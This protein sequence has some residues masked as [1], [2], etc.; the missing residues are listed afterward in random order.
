MAQMVRDGTH[1]ARTAQ[2]RVRLFA[3][4]VCMAVAHCA[5]GPA[6]AQTQVLP[7]LVITVP[8][9]AQQQPQAPAAQAP[10]PAQPKPAPKPKPAQQS[11]PKAAPTKS[12]SASEGGGTGSVSGPGVQSISV[13]VNGDPI[14]NYEIEQRA[15]FLS[16]QSNIGERAQENF[17]RLVSQD[18]T[19]QRLRAILQETI[20]AN[21]GKTQQQV[22]AIFEERKK[23]FAMNLQKQ[24]V[25][26]ARASVVPAK[27]KEA[28]DE[29]IEEQL[30]IQEAKRLGSGVDDKQVDDSFKVIASRNKMTP[31]Q[32]SDHMRNMGVDPSTM[33]QKIRSSMAWSEVVRRQIS[34]NVTVSQ[35]EIDRLVGTAGANDTDIEVEVR[36]I[37]LPLPPKLD[38]KTID[39]RL[40]EADTLTSS[41]TS[42]RTMASLSNKVQGAKFEDIGAR[43][44]SS[45]EEPLKSQIAAAKD[46]Q[47]LP[48]N[49]TKTGIELYA[50]CGRKTVKANEEKRQQLAA[51]MRQKEFEAHA[52]GLLLQLQQKA[53]IERR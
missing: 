25:E 1:Q 37:V 17:K 18:S 36:R 20:E 28:I 42:C 6:F 33:R 29:L 30:K 52:R 23:Q 27:R 3:T 11:A 35:I 53:V 5:S 49:T 51:E 16:L 10:A 38:K 43:K 9:P 22:M 34:P 7:G 2:G 31:A 44:V 12:A 4:G 15:R 21:P 47:L 50:V 41:F 24:A 19:N 14:T 40:A 32:F 39:Q 8:Q 13:V 26:S 45:F 46:G 48:P